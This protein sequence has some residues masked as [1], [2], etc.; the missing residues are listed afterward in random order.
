MRI[1]SQELT[2]PSVTMINSCP[3]RSRLNQC[4]ASISM[5]RL[6]AAAGHASTIRCSDRSSRAKSSASRLDPAGK[7]E[8]SRKTRRARGLC[9][10][11]RKR[12]MSDWITGAILLS[13]CQ[14]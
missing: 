6:S 7:Q 3:S 11:H 13:D 9:Q 12:W 2:L 8:R 4:R 14:L 5:P 1:S 10:G